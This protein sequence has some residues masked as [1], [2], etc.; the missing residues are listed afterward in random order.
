MKR[1]MEYEPISRKYH[2]PMDRFRITKQ[3]Q[4]LEPARHDEKVL[5]KIPIKQLSAM[6]FRLLSAFDKGIKPRKEV[7]SATR[8]DDKQRC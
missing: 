1:V 3:I 6:R 8:R 4:G 5:N 2:C 7:D